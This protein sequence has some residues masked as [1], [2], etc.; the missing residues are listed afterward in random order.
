MSASS[1]LL[2]RSIHRFALAMAVAVAMI[3]PLGYWLVVH[4]N[5]SAALDFKAKVKAAALSG[6][7][8]SN[9][10]TW[11]FAEN[12]MQGLLLHE[13]VPLD[14]ERVLVFASDDEMVAE[15]GRTPPDPVLE[16]TYPLYD[17][18][19]SVGRIVVAGSLR[20][21]VWNTLA[22]ALLGLLLS[23]MVYAVVNTLP[24]R[25]LREAT[26]ALSA[27]ELRF[28][29][30]FESVPNI[31]VRGYDADHSIIFWNPASERLY[32]HSAAEAIG[33]RLEALI[34]PPAA[35][36]ALTAALDAWQAGG[37]PIAAGEIVL[38]RKDG[39]P[40]TVYSSHTLLSN[41]AGQPETYSIDVELTELK[42]TEAELR[43]YQAHLEDMV[44]ERTLALSIAKEAAEAASRAK[45]SFLANM[46]HELRTPMN[47]VM[48]MLELARRRMS[49]PRGI[50]QLDKAKAG[51]DHLLAII[52]NIL[53][54][55]KIEAERFILDEA[56]FTL[57]AVLDHIDTLVG[58]RAVEKGL[59]LK[60][61]PAP[62]IAAKAY[63]GDSLRLGQI[64]V[65][66]TGNAVKFTEHGTI[67]LRVREV[68][69]RADSALLRFEIEDHGIG[70]SAEEKR[71]LFTAFEQAD[72]S[73]TRKYGGTGLG[74]AISKQL[75]RMMGGEIGVESVP[76]AGST[77]WFTARFVRVAAI[78]SAPA[79]ASESAQEKLKL[80]FGGASI[81]LAED[82]PVSREVT[83]MLLRD[84]GL[85]VEQAEDGAEALR[86]AQERRYD[87]ILMDMQ[88]PGLNG[89][90]ATRAI[91]SGSRNTATPILALTANAFAEDRQVCLE[92][93]MNDHIVKPID[94]NLLFAILLRWLEKSR[95]DK[96]NAMASFGR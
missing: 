13:P 31:A 46:S 73:M 18:G 23:I 38:Q 61:E 29:S 25:A 78:P 88:M 87:L 9:P 94:S 33:Q 70:I 65:N 83:M 64:L 85:E 57:G 54:I 91:R 36:P 79:G 2:E 52:N 80:E 76:G 92:A 10:D 4:Q 60:I 95:A 84:L 3:I 71:R 86:R 53:D 5:Y 59:I 49:D 93:G 11:M 68:D 69:A 74:L 24:L 43:S 22:A 17:A 96:S 14:D 72:G 16:R 45:S 75:A 6:A 66:L 81:L 8:A 32:G 15:I 26:A 30:I 12:R 58:Q 48:G 44:N 56:D 77:F 27:S 40:V 21:L 1:N 63:R 37:A 82:E 50:D 62:G 42:R 39:S 20:P 90:D 28:R 19:R 35:R 89:V 7:I 51:A 55:S 41:A 34:F 47:A 67:R